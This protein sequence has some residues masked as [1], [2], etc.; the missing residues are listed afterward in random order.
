M[1]LGDMHRRP[2]ER[3]TDLPL[4]PGRDS[5]EISIL[6]LLSTVLQ[7]RRM[8]AAMAAALFLA[9][10]AINLIRPRTYT[11]STSFMASQQRA[12]NAIS[13]LVA[14]F[15]LTLGGDPGTSPPFYVDLV[16]SKEMEGEVV[17]TRFRVPTSRGEREMTLTDYYGITPDAAPARRRALAIRRLDRDVGTTTARQTGVVGVTVTTKDPSLSAQIAQRFLD[18]VNHFNVEVRQSQASAERRF[19]ASRL[20]EARAELGEAE[21][22]VREFLEQN[23]DYRNSPMLIFQHDRLQREVSLKND[24]FTSLAQLYEQARLDEVKDIPVITVIEAPQP[25]AL[26]DPRALLVKGVLA[27]VVGAALGVLAAFLVEFFASGGREDP[28]TVHEFRLLAREALADVR[29]PWRLLRR[30]PRRTSS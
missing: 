8:V 3:P 22:R 1:T 20:T 18:L 26:P 16:R 11:A 5:D 10:I 19:A 4:G 17:D 9:V 24:V 25:P 30:S 7:R 28:N 29:R 2:L 6:G 23:R 14:Q 21:S 13:G 15:G 27:L 12:P